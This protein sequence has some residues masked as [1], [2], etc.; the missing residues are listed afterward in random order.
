MSEESEFIDLNAEIKVFESM[1]KEDGYTKKNNTKRAIQKLTQDGKKITENKIENSINYNSLSVEE[2]KLIDKINQNISIE[3]STSI[4]QYGMDTQTEIARFSDTILK[5]VKNKGIGKLGNL[6]TNLV[7]EIKNFDSNVAKSNNNFLNFFKNT[8]KRLSKL[9]AEYKTIENNIDK[10]EKKLEDYRIQMLKDVVI[11]D[12]MYEENLE[13]IK[14]ISLY[15]IGGDKKI[16]ELT[17]QLK[18]LK[19][20]ANQTKNQLDIQKVNDM[21]NTIDRFEKKINDLKITRIISIQMISQIRL[22]QTKE[23]ELIEKIQST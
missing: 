19:E 4:L 11:F 7:V 1:L 2:K 13:Y 14:V 6:L 8:Q 15:I 5:R 3:D 16:E 17:N 9:I 21:K 18:T 22:L 12:E 10:I 20:K 23:S